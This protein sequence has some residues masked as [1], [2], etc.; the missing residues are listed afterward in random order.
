MKI[1][2]Q[3]IV[4]YLIWL[5]LSVEVVIS[6]WLGQWNEA[7]MAVFTLGLTLLPALFADRLGFK[8]P[9]TFGAIIVIFLFATLFLGEVGGFYERYWWW[10]LVLHSGAA[11]AGGLVGFVLVFMLF[12]GDRFAA[13]PLALAYLAF[14]SA[15]AIGALW[16]VFEFGM[17]AV[18]GLNMQKSG[19]E[20]TMWDMIVN[21]I[22]A[23]IA[24]TAG[25]FYLLGRHFGGLV[26]L[27]EQLIDANKK[28][29]RKNK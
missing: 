5:T 18:F 16:E 26:R 4:V 7:F 8:L 25:Y 3:S 1:A 24:A 10:D 17:D 19:L 6:L 27:I 11:M 13:P 20:D 15:V 22:G 29:F 2:R 21:T 23:G 28:F 9:M 12:E 14:S